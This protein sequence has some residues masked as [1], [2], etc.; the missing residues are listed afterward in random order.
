MFKILNF[1]RWSQEQLQRKESTEPCSSL[2][3][4]KRFEQFVLWFKSYH[5]I[6]LKYILISFLIGEYLL[7]M[8][9]NIIFFVHSVIPFVLCFQGYFFFVNIFQ[10]DGFSSIDTIGI[11][12]YRNF[13]R[14]AHF[15][16]NLFQGCFYLEESTIIGHQYNL[17]IP[18]SSSVVATI[19]VRTVIC[20]YL[21]LKHK[22]IQSCSDFQ[23]F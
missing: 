2:W 12:N 8:T 9:D 7:K 22:K 5:Y 3:T 13:Y 23:C 14:N 1:Y 21:L 11:S 19:K 4:L 6:L 15:R 17:R 18:E 20:Y 16:R 10:S